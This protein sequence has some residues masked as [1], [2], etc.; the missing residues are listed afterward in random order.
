MQDITGDEELR[1]EQATLIGPV[2]TIPQEYPFLD[3][4]LI[5]IVIPQ[6][7]SFSE[8]QLIE[9]LEAELKFKS[10]DQII[11]YRKQHRWVE[12]F[13]S[14]KL[15]NSNQN[16][17]MLKEG[18]VYLITGGLGGIGLTLAEYL[19]QTVKAKLILIGRANFP[20]RND[21]EKWLASHDAEDSTSGKI[22]KLYE[23]EKL[24]AKVLVVSAD[25]TNLQQM[26]T[27]IAKATAQ[28]G[29]IDGVIHGAG[30]PGG[31]FIQQKTREQ[32]ENVMTPK[33]KGTLILDTIFR[34]S[35]LDFF[36]VLSSLNSIISALG[37][38]DYCAANAFLD[39]FAHRNSKRYSTFTISIN[40]DGWQEVGMAANSAQKFSEKLDY[41]FL[42][43]TLLP[44]EGVEAFSRILHNQLPQVLVST[45]DFLTRLQQ[46]EH[47]VKEESL[48]LAIHSRPQLNNFYVA[49]SNW[50]EEKIADIWQELLG[51]Q[52][53]GIHDNFFE[54]GGDSLIAVQV[55]S[56]LRKTFSIQ[57]SVA[58]LLA[59]PTIAEIASKLEKQRE[60]YNDLDAM[61][62]EEMTI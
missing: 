57:F 60:P 18:G 34:D 53:V 10:S 23:L 3:C 43:Q 19:A 52:Q 28:F 12:S 11:A 25:V 13:E 5:D 26:Q 29:K 9:Q 54:L 47:S 21:W 22:R 7:G 49:P 46:V 41:T 45:V 6:P 16:I 24:G 1:P 20:D 62:R 59:S 17:Q 35:K 61:E 39:A 15:D 38:V 31:G 48:S 37:Q 30:V 14:V 36:I 55:L 2:R 50:V 33:I 51:I 4:R 42:Q 40:W 44:A 27:A 32:A 58:I 56:R 8:K